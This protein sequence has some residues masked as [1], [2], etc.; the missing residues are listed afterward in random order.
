LLKGA[1]HHKLPALHFA[2]AALHRTA[3]CPTL[4]CLFLRHKLLKA[5]PHHKSPAPRVAQSRTRPQVAQKCSAPRVACTTSCSKPHLHK[6]L[7]TTSCS[8]PHCTGLHPSCIR[9]SFSGLLSPKLHCATSC[10][11][12]QCITSSSK[13]QVAQ[14]C[15]VPQVV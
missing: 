15:A 6:L 3:N 12:L 2:Q 5:A 14:S 7:K 10:S 4:H 8:K 11:K 9:C 1:P 13:L